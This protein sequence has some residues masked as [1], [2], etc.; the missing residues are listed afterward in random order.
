MTENLYSA[1]SQHE[2]K[3]QETQTIFSSSPSLNKKKNL[4]DIYHPRHFSVQTKCGPGMPHIRF[5]QAG[6]QARQ[7][8]LEELT[9]IW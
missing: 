2:K 8:G 6:R 1:Q 9:Q 5:R 4:T 7:A 3:Q